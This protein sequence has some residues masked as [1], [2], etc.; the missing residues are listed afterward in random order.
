MTSIFEDVKLTWGGRDYVIPASRVLGG[1]ACIEEV[2]TL[3]E[4][5][6][7]SAR[8]TAPMAK[9]SQAFTAVLNYVG[10]RVS[11]EEVYRS[12]FDR[13]SQDNVISAV[14]TLLQLMTPPSLS[15]APSAGN[16]SAADAKSSKRRTRRQSAKGG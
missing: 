7:Y 6:Q 10:A 9:L 12:M 2:L 15:E 1:I 8:G 5:S 13:G 16:A 11:A 14:V 4:L 3:H